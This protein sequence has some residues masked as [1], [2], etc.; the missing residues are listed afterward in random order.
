M[1][2]PNA[3]NVCRR[4]AF[5]SREIGPSEPCLQ[6]HY[7]T[8]KLRGRGVRAVSKDK[9]APTSGGFPGGRNPRSPPSGPIRTQNGPPKNNKRPPK[10]LQTARTPLRDVL[11][12]PE[13]TWISQIPGK[14]SGFIRI[15]RPNFGLDFFVSDLPDKFNRFP[16]QWLQESGFPGSPPRGGGGRCAVA[17]EAPCHAALRVG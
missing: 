3:Y 17:C 9:M 6:F 13:N 15:L 2:P 12:P 4:A 1:H 10:L 8:C 11:L 7:G 16:G 5:Q 14:C